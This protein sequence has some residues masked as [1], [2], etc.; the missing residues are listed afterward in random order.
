MANIG[1][2][3]KGRELRSPFIVA[4]GPLTAK[5]ERIKAAYEAGAGA[6]VIKHALYQQPYAGRPRWYYE[7]EIGILVCS[8]K[9]FN[10]GDS[11]DLIKEVKKITRGMP[12]IANMSG[13]SDN[14]EG[15][16]QAARD[17]KKAGA[18]L[19]E[20]NLNC[21]N[22]G[23]STDLEVDV[24]EIRG[25]SVGQIPQLAA[26][27]TG[28]VKAEV[29]IPVMNKLTAEGGRMV[30]VARACAEAG[31]DL[32]NARAGLIGAP[33]LD[34]YNGG[35]PKIY[36][37]ENAIFGGVSGQWNRFHGNRF[38][39]QVAEAVDIPVLGGGGIAKWEHAVETIMYGA[40]AVQICTSIMLNGFSIIS[41]M[42]KGLHEYFE[43]MGYDD[44]EQIR[45]LAAKYI[46]TPRELVF[47]DVK[48]SV[49]KNKCNGCGTCTKI[50]TCEALSLK[51]GKA[52]ID[53]DACVGCNLCLNVCPRKAI[54]AVI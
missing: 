35:R 34:I 31:A 9:R 23:L 46:V 40:H 32:I 43:K 17:L 3:L 52:R 30:E 54:F 53:H 39:A 51:E 21:P 10:I 1:L 42:V 5:L 27:I 20:L 33:G 37:L 29:D 18:D 50:A 22:F 7:D 41:S 15:W 49:D 14:L 8:D 48:F 26:A 24:K 12:V 19:L 36:G 25:A 47:H 45:G 38:V 6:V 16:I 2:E 4:S 13:P 11:V 44:L 28:A